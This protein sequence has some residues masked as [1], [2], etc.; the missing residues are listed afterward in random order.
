VAY[1]WVCGLTSTA[2]V[3]TFVG[4][5]RFKPLNLN[6]QLLV[7]PRS[8]FGAEGRNPGLIKEDR[9][10][11]KERNFG[12]TGGNGEPEMNLGAKKEG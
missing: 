7:K 6:D 3:R 11:K 5:C 12:Q 1:I 2:E 9:A 4:L 10:R 8:E